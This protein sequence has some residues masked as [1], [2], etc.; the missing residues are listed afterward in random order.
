MV[1]PTTKKNLRKR[2]SLIQ[3]IRILTRV[4]VL[5]DKLLFYK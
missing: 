5:I 3:M 4:Q 1:T 2:K